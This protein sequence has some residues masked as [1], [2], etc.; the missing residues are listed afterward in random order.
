MVRSIVR[1]FGP[2]FLSADMS[3]VKLSGSGPN[4]RSLFRTGSRQ[5]GSIFAENLFFRSDRTGPTGGR[6]IHA[7]YG[8]GVI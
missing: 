3:E 2:E 4:V 1:D 7:Q 5:F 8:R 6:F